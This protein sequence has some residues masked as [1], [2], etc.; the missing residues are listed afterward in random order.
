L[1][2]LSEIISSFGPEETR[3]FRT[4][5]NR[6]KD[7]KNRKDSELFALYLKYITPDRNILLNA[8]YPEDKNPEA[9]HATRKR[10]IRQLLDFIAAEESAREDIPER[11][12]ENLLIVC[13][14]LFERKCEEAGWH[15][16]KQA[17]DQALKL[18]SYRLLNEI[19]NLQIEKSLSE[20]APDLPE[21]LAGK[22]KYYDLYRQEENARTANQLIRYELNKAVVSG[23]EINLQ[24]IIKNVL[25]DYELN[26]A[27]SL[28]PRLAWN[29]ISITRSVILS[30][31]DFNSFEP[32]V[33]SH[34]N[35]LENQ[36][37]F[38]SQTQFY[39]NSLL[40][41]IAH[42]LYRNKKFVKAEFYLKILHEAITTGDKKYFL[43][44]YPD[45]VLLQ[46]AVLNYSG[47]NKD[48][49][50]L[51]EG[52]AGGK[53][54]KLTKAQLFN[55]YLNLSTYYFQQKDYNKS[56]RQFRNIQHSDKWLR[57]VMG[58][59]WVMKKDIIECI[60]QFE[61]GN[62][63]L[64]EKRIRSIENNFAELLSRPRY[65]R[66]KTFL[67]FVKEINRNPQIA[68]TREFEQK[69]EQ[70]F[71]FV[72]PAYEDIQAM[73]FYG[74]LKSKMVRKDYYQVLLELVKG[75]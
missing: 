74:W 69:V 45:Y 67:D 12:V 55:T 47:R 33:I 48:A 37:R 70:S 31:K 16:L 62:N 1:D 14:N 4:F 57:K 51:L 17:E 42:V 36:G 26:E 38:T 63:D 18:E 64:I 75:Y 61:L 32:Y 11:P 53:Q 19:Y 20:F 73:T 25:N 9:Y 6:F 27:V 30:E 22:K 60:N 5:L 50:K 8:L 54:I 3:K 23:S 39:R 15:L 34:F 59:E 58:M 41:M 43:R 7:K 46:A 28:S 44:F 2:I 29:L 52:L 68:A 10:L 56:V 72:G 65:Q 40:Y 71:E 49:V 35:N 66:V 24:Q 21:I 13:K